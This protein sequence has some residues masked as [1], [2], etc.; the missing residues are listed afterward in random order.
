MD[1]KR[2]VSIV[3]CIILA[4]ACLS[5]CGKRSSG[6]ERFSAQIYG[7]FDTVV[8][9][10]AYCRDQAVFDA[11]KNE[12]QEELLYYH[13]LF[14]IYNSYEGLNN[15]KTVNDKAGG[16]PVEV[17]AELAELV[18]LGIDMHKNTGGKV[19]IAMGAVLSLWHEA[20]EYSLD[21]PE[22]AYV[23]AE[24]DLREAAEH[25]DIGKVQVSQGTGGGKGTVALADPEMSL[26][27][28]AVGKGFAV[29]KVARKLE[30]EG[31]TGILI[32]AGGN[33]RAI[34]SKPDGGWKVAVE[35]P[36]SS[37]S[38]A[39]VALIEMNGGSLVTSGSYQR[40]YEVGGVRYHHI[41]DGET[42]QPENRFLSVT[43]RTADSGAADALSTA[44]FN[45]DPSEG[46]QFVDHL[47]GVEALWV[48]NDK[49]LQTS[50]GW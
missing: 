6:G 32:N 44:V 13:R 45:M 3:I 15:A 39:Y 35:D 31:R 2:I 37:G 11:L 50:A 27:L 9:V 21:H 17:P 25:C 33:V 16:G 23:P 40:W 8:T 46:L 4:A 18:Q 5:G 48:L 47:E 7:A 30:A 1:R 49:S 36:D 28:G 24:T 22:S 19:N 29:E 10:T 26:D 14:D 41:I 20:R 42:L 12:M 43:I 38:Q 34:G